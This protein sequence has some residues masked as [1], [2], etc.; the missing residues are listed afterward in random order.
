LAAITVG[1]YLATG[2]PLPGWLRARP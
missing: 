2:A 1:V